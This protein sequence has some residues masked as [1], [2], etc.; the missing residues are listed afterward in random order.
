VLNGTYFLT[1]IFTPATLAQWSGEIFEFRDAD[2]TFRRKRTAFSPS[3][4][5]STTVESGTFQY[6]GNSVVLETDSVECGSGGVVMSSDGTWLYTVGGGGF[7]LQAG[8]GLV[9]LHYLTAI[10]FGI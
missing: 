9:E 4:Q 8:G 5:G 2:G 7:K 1:D 6:V 3:G 10:G